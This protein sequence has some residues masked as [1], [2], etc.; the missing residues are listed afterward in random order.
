[1]NSEWSKLVVFFSIS[2]EI[3]ILTGAG[4]ITGQWI[5][6]RFGVVPDELTL[7]LGLVGLGISL[8]RA[9]LWNKKL[10]GSK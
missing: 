5:S 1:M 9:Y 3:L 7:I 2:V 8:Y 4:V 6:E 10:T